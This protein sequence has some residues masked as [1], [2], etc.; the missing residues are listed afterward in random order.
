M[1]ARARAITYDRYSHAAGGRVIAG[2]L[3]TGPTPERGARE[4]RR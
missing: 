1:S 2:A 3:G 4:G